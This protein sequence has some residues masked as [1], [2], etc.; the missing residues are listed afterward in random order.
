MVSTAVCGTVSE[1]SNPS[2]HPAKKAFI[3]RVFL[4]RMKEC[5][6]LWYNNK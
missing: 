5:S 4:I 6:N 1:G 3:L 2:S